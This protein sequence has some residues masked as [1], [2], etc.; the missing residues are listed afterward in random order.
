MYIYIYIYTHTRTIR[1]ICNHNYVCTPC[2]AIR[3]LSAGG[4]RG[5]RLIESY[6]STF[7]Y[8]ILSC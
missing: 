6:V 4:A 7:G 5:A 3:M 8:V 2:K 1:Y